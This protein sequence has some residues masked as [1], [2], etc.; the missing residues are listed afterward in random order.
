MTNRASERLHTASI[1]VTEGTTAP[2]NLPLN[3]STAGMGERTMS[4][5]SWSIRHQ[6]TDCEPPADPAWHSTRAGTK[7]AVPAELDGT[8]MG[9]T[10]PLA[11]SYLNSLRPP[12]WRKVLV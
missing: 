7:E 3:S 5:P 12:I 10:G 6:Y 8:G 11:G 4:N 1:E 2:S 9:P